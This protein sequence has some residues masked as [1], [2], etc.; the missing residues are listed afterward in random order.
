MPISKTQS[1]PQSN[2]LS[3]YKLTGR[4]CRDVKIILGE[5]ERIDSKE[6]AQAILEYDKHKKLLFTDS[7]EHWI[8]LCRDAKYYLQHG[9]T[10]LLDDL[11]AAYRYC[12]NKG[13]KLIANISQYINGK[14][15]I[16]KN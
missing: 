5:N 9:D 6:K 7:K 16:A 3:Q 2:I 15:I 1:T 10:N 11:T 12:K 14:N 13:K 8:L 4:V